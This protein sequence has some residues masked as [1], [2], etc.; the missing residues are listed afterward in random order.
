VITQLLNIGLVPVFQHAGLA[1]AIGLGAVINAV[2]LLVGLMRR[3][4]YKPLAGWGRF[5]LQ[6]VAASAL[7]AVFL[8]WFGGRQDWPELR[9]QLLQRIALLALALIGG[10]AIYLGSLWAAGLRFRQLLRR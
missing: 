7:L 9:S 5:T 1:L 3:G 6:V 4:S 8:L 2:W 10:A